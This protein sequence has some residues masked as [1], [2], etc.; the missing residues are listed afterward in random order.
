MLGGSF[1]SSV[2]GV[3]AL[4]AVAGAAVAGPYR[5]PEKA[6][7]TPRPAIGEAGMVPPPAPPGAPLD[8]ATLSAPVATAAA[9]QAKR[10]VRNP[11]SMF[12]NG[13]RSTFTHDPAS[14]RPTFNA[15]QK[16]P[17]AALPDGLVLT[18]GGFTIDQT[19]R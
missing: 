4:L 6:Q 9:G 18:A 11:A 5:P 1:A 13:D 8:L 16:D 17:E 19:A 7:V 14:V 10:D 3:V 15:P 12:K 2:W